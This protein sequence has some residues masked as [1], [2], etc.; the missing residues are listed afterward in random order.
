MGQRNSRSLRLC[1]PQSHCG[2]P[3]QGKTPELW[4]TCVGF[5]SISS[6]RDYTPI[7]APPQGKSPYGYRGQDNQGLCF[8]PI[9]LCILLGVV[10]LSALGKIG[11]YQYLVV[12]TLDSMNPLQKPT[13]GPGNL[14][15]T[16]IHLDAGVTVCTTKHML[17]DFCFSK[18]SRFLLVQEMSAGFFCT[19]KAWTLRKQ[20]TKNH[21]MQV[22][23]F[24]CHGCIF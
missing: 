17:L 10:Q 8:F 16:E 4:F 9:E 14:T 11:P 18:S 23:K 21:G 5:V 1:S 12:Q 24:Q 2:G 19:R 7:S 20:G 13:A 15:Y 6:C 3:C 22:G